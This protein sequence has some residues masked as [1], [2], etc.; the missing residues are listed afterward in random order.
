M[1]HRVP[2]VPP[3]QRRHGDAAN[4]R[5]VVWVVVCWYRLRLVR[6]CA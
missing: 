4:A 2:M 1:L 3:T 5:I 6:R